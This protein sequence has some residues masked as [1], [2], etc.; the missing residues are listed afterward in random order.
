MVRPARPM[1]VLL[2]KTKPPKSPVFYRHATAFPVS[3]R[4]V[5]ARTESM[6]NSELACPLLSLNHQR[7]LR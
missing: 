6:L 1:S 3:K 5:S 2:P 4:Q 7:T